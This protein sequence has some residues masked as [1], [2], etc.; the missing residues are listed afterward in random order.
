ME[1]QPMRTA[2]VQY[3]GAKIN[4][5]DLAPYLT[6]GFNPGFGSL[7]ARIRIP[8]TDR[9]AVCSNMQF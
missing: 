3:I 7:F 4:F 5:G 9:R 2:A 1:S 8:F 6:Y